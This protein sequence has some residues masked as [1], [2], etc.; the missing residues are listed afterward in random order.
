ML[1]CSCVLC[2]LQSQMQ[3]GLS[4]HHFCRLLGFL[5]LNAHLAVQLPRVKMEARL[6]VT[7][8]AFSRVFHHHLIKKLGSRHRAHELTRCTSTQDAKPSDARH[9][10]KHKTVLCWPLSFQSL[11]RIFDVMVLEECKASLLHGHGRID[12]GRWHQWLHVCKERHML[13]QLTG[14]RTARSSG[15]QAISVR[16]SIAY[17]YCVSIDG[18]DGRHGVVHL[19]ANI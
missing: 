7:A 5:G 17:L 13:P 6:Q 10:F 4:A 1:R 16:Y 15:S 2:N 11:Q 3:T 19:S 12:S 9:T 18:T 14:L 8:L